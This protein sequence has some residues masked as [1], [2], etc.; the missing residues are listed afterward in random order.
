[1]GFYILYITKKQII[2]IYVIGLSANDDKIDMIHI[3]G[4]FSPMQKEFNCFLS[5]PKT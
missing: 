3:K 5:S 1:M 2:F 4:T